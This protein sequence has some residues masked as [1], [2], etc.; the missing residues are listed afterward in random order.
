MKALHLS[1]FSRIRSYCLAAL[2]YSGGGLLH[3]NGI[4]HRVAN[5]NTACVSHGNLKDKIKFIIE[6]G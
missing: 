4:K 1:L 5:W 6:V 2:E 3:E